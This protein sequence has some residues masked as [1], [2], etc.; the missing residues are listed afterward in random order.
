MSEK[1]K[2]SWWVKEENDG[3]TFI[4]G[5]TPVF[6]V[7]KNTNHGFEKV[8]LRAVNNIGAITPSPTALIYGFAMVEKVFIELY[9]E[10]IEPNRQRALEIYAE[11]VE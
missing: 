2:T 10:T 9:N 4:Y 7:K 1:I 5:H 6:T 8:E 11:Y 3:H